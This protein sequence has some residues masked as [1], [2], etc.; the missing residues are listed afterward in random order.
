MIAES[1]SN[2]TFNDTEELL[3]PVLPAVTGL[4]GDLQVVGVEGLSGA[5]TIRYSGPEKLIYGVELTLKDN[6]LIKTVKF[7]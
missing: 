5:V 2:A 7:E 3:A 6:P 4:G 1:G